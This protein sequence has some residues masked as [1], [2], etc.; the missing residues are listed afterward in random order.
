VT[1]SR[2][3]AKESRPP[4]GVVIAGRFH[5]G[6]RLAE[7]GAVEVFEGVDAENGTNVRLKSL[8]ID[9]LPSGLP[10]RLEHEAGVL[11]SIRHPHVVPILFQGR[12]RGRFWFVTHQSLD[13]TSLSSRLQSGPLST[14]ESVSICLDVVT[15]LA[16]IH[17]HGI[18]H[19][20]IQPGDVICPAQ[21]T[22]IAAQLTW[23]GALDS[24]FC[25]SSAAPGLLDVS[26]YSAPERSRIICGDINESSDL[27]SVGCL[28]FHCLVGHPP[29]DGGDLNQ[30][31]WNQ[32]TQ[33]IRGP[34]E[35]GID[36]PRALDE[37]LQR[38]LAREVH[39][40]YQ[41]AEAVRRDL[42]EL[43]ASLRAGIAD[44]DLTIGAYDH[45]G[46]LAH[47]AFVARQSEVA[48]L[49]KQI[50]QTRAGTP[51]L[52]VVE[53]QS[54][55]GKTRLLS[56]FAARCTKAGLWVFEGRATQDV[57]HP[58]QLFEGVAASFVA[59]AQ[60]QPQLAEN[61]S[62][63]LQGQTADLIAA[64]P[65]L[66][67]V[68]RSE[69][70]GSSSEF[71]G[72]SR[73]L[74]A[75]AD[76]LDALGTREHPAVVILD[77]VQWA[78]DLLYRL[79]L[80][81]QVL[82]SQ[83]QGEKR[84]VQL[85]VSYRS[86]EVSATNP[87]RRIEP[88]ARVAIGPLKDAE[89]LRLLESMA[90]PLPQP[91]VEVVTRLADGSPFMAS[92]ILHGLVESRALISEAQTW[93]VDAKALDV[94]R[95]S[96]HAAAFLAR[97]LS[98]LDPVTLAFLEAGSLLGSEFSLE[99]AITLSELSPADALTAANDA[100]QRH[101]LWWN[102][103]DGCAFVHDKIRETL[104]ERQPPQ[105]KS[106][107][108]SR[109]ADHLLKQTSLPHAELAIHLDAANR[110][111]EALN[112]ALLAAT[113]ARQQHALELSEQLFRIA[114]RAAA[115]RPNAM[116]FQIAEGLG[117]VQMLRGR[118]VEAG[119]QFNRAAGFAEGP[120]S[121]AEVCCKRGELSIKRGDMHAALAQYSEGL[122]TVGFR[123]PTWRIT[124]AAWLSWEIL[125][126]ALHTAFR[127]WFVHRTPRPPDARERLAMRM[128]S[129]YAHACW[130]CRSLPLAMWAHLRC[131]NLGEVF[132]A[133]LELA[134]AYSDHAPAMVLTRWISRGTAYAE[135]SLAIRRDQGDLWGQGQS[136]HYYG[137]VQY[138]AGR[139]DECIEL[140]G[141]AVRI[142]E[143]LGDYWQ[144]HIARYQ[145][146]AARLHLGDL[147]GAAD[148]S[149]RNHASGMML[150]DEQ[151]SGIILDVWARATTGRVPPE[152]LER[153][154]A[155]ERH[156][157]Q[158]TAQVL[159]AS[160][161]QDLHLGEVAR[162]VE[163]LE[164]ARSI[165][166]TSG[167]RNPYT[168]PVYVWLATAC[169]ILAERDHS[170]DLSIRRRHLAIAESA[171]RVATWESWR[172]RN[173][174]PQVLREKAM[175]AVM[176]GR[177]SRARR[178]FHRSLA[179]A[180]SHRAPHERALTLSEM[181]RVGSQ[182]GWS[183]A[184]ALEQS[185]R[186]E[187]AKLATHDASRP[188]TGETTA[189]PSVSLIDRFDT[190]LKTGR[191]IVS[192]FSKQTI[193]EKLTHAA[194]RL[195]RA[196][197]AEVVWF[198]EGSSSEK[199]DWP[200]VLEGSGI[201][202]PKTEA[203]AED[204]SRSALRAPIQMRGKVVAALSV[205]H[206][207]V[208][209]L[210]GSDEERIAG[211]L[212]TLAGAAFENAEGFAKLEQL[213]ATLE[214]KVA[215]RT[216]SLQERALQ[217]AQS[218]QDLERTTTELRVTQDQ[219]LVS[220]AIAESAN[221]A[222]GR[223][224]A[225]M[226]HEIRTPMNGVIGMA[227]LALATEL[228]NR[229]R[230]YVSTISQSAKAL[231]AML[232][233]VLDFS[234]IEAGKL[235]LESRPF[236]LHETI[237][238][239]VRLLSVSAWQK[240]LDIST[241]LSPTLPATVVGD[242]ARLRQVLLNLIGNAVKFTSSGGV[243]IRGDVDADGSIHLVVRDS[244]IGIP[245]DRIDRIFQ[246]FDQGE[247]SIT[248][249]FGGTGL[250]LAI[251]SQIVSL[252]GGRIWVESE[253][254]HGSEFH[255]SIPA[256]LPDAGEPPVTISSRP[257]AGKGLI[258]SSKDEVGRSHAAWLDTWGFT[259]ATL[260]R[261]DDVK[262]A[263]VGW[264]DLDVLLFD[265]SANADDEMEGLAQIAK[266]GLID[267]GRIVTL[268]PAGAEHAASRAQQAG[269]TH[270]LMK[271]VSPRD[272]HDA[273]TSAMSGERT[274]PNPVEVR[275][276]RSEVALRILVVDDSPINQE[277]AVGLL[278]LMGHQATPAESGQEALDLLRDREFDV[279]FMDVEM[280]DMDG[281]ETTR[282]LREREGS[283]RV[284]VLA[285]SAHVMDEVRQDCLAAGM[286]GFVSKPVDPVE[287]R[288]V[289][290][291]IVRQTKSDGVAS[292]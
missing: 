2:E 70:S 108:H 18:L 185:A 198:G 236:P 229:Q 142:L 128:L 275:P 218:N 110:G 177:P 186:T 266:A 32:A 215:D 164:R 244:G 232:N 123:V 201:L 289:L 56:E 256:R 264:P 21:D 77:D 22:G 55:Y 102:W 106:Q 117:S 245:R 172:F 150:G 211:F 54:G 61:V 51:Q 134:Q 19:T 14:T 82:Q 91:A 86:D 118:Y 120:E 190:L 58:F 47:P 137:V 255:V 282:R 272:V 252:M 225:A 115:L 111:E 129:G 268:L 187:L 265:V 99:M 246:A 50:E 53:G 7:S 92:A 191:V 72:E 141:R 230:T 75:M 178:L 114:D 119:E 210:F 208:A 29:H 26:R 148:E 69:E 278:E 31:L 284:P 133:S 173:D 66:A 180:E 89:I 46:S 263:L 223:F 243:D 44:P 280:P 80:R 281:F 149:Q 247:A 62:A 4:D 184:E 65:G 140:C 101:L 84:Y 152:L 220:K 258:F 179:K 87:L 206:N 212:S 205:V 71:A 131:M 188:G 181:A 277:V 238:E 285:M 20:G 13:S 166:E 136:L 292:T 168:L 273:L 25:E 38:L 260:D 157:A 254:G 100:R 226:S 176:R 57:G 221:V 154:L 88:G 235:E 30:L 125:I 224:L 214:R 41:T 35:R 81:W 98:Q 74:A 248:R 155:R 227:E 291:E 219:L 234:K 249:R 237:V 217:L 161:V 156:D 139:Y 67:A 104:L 147:R 267:A 189:Q 202:P 1:E 37:L 216:A 200:E 78:D 183:D 109:A 112:H 90:G 287:I 45:R 85:V 145:I 288:D 96:R 143:R 169:R 105:K 290:A 196:E 192:S 9:S 79:M 158:G 160:A 259:P 12:D 132:D 16:E 122:R 76:F 165:V 274:V 95:S 42:E 121:R 5:C 64:L 171:L 151:A 52:T 146:A 63:R 24:L 113:D 83:R 240:G 251:S 36:I 33:P 49:D 39:T 197:Q 199:G 163:T 261:M 153:E 11:A 144:V 270:I 193:S 3:A 170:L 124:V 73:L 34:R 97:R 135:R 27:Y 10:I 48:I 233:D 253:F 271:P 222:K 6:A 195:L 17:R 59:A 28:L 257:L 94:V 23:P 242:S 262:L 209:G 126:Q 279:V 182:L 159:L 203:S 127:G 174:I 276:S 68:L 93:T 213:N 175:I 162:S 43:L 103:N 231:L 269:M 283:R 60:S 250:G 130:Y 194:K 138:A 228:S 15:G 8:K 239:S 286:D 204:E 116:R 167:V 40:R 107:L 241:R 207:H